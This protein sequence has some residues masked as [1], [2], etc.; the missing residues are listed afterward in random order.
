LRLRIWRWTHWPSSR[1]HQMSS[2]R[3]P[4]TGCNPVF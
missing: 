1:C 4:G 3:F 2:A